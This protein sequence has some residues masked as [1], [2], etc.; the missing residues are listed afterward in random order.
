MSDELWCVVGNVKKEIPFGPDG[1]ELKSGLKHFKAGAKIHIVGSYSGGCENIIAIGHH[2]KSGKYIHC[3]IRVREVENLRV[4]IIY[5]KSI[6]SF[7]CG[8]QPNG[9]EIHTTQ[10]SAEYL[11]ELI[12]L[13]Q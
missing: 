5:S 1:G 2:R 6:L 13:W 4:K 8:F 9:A 3:V 11:A 10:E 7:L 12:S